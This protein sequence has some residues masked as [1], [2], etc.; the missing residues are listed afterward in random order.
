MLRPVVEIFIGGVLACS[1]LVLGE[2]A[3][4]IVLDGMT[5]YGALLVVALIV[6]FSNLFGDRK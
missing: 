4:H 6:I 3:Q 2:A 5:I 1:L